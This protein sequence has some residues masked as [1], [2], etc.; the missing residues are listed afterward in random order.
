MAYK[1]LPLAAVFE[2]SKMLQTHIEQQ[3]G[4]GDSCCSFLKPAA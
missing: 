4:K 3:A 2:A 1:L